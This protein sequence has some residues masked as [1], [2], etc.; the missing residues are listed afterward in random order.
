MRKII[1]TVALALLVPLSLLAAD[2]KDTKKDTGAM[3]QLQTVDKS[4]KS[5][6]KDA[7]AG[8]LESAK[9]KSGQGIDTPA[10]SK[11]KVKAPPAK[12]QDANAIAKTETAKQK[13]RDKE[14]A[15][16]VKL[17][18]PKKAPPSPK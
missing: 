6:A 3:K 17:D 4:S 1:T 9:Q 11:N 7:K 18:D 12:P 14:T 8:K 16:K 10:T 15:K 2:N 13:Q 5:A